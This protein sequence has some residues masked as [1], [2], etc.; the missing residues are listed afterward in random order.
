MKL[1]T[2]NA[3]EQCEGSIKAIKWTLSGYLGIM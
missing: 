1:T 3:K 2:N